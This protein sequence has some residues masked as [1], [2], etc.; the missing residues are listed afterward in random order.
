MMRV[1]T[2]QQVATHLG[3][4]PGTVSAV[5][6]DSPAAKGIPQRTKDRI[7]AGAR[8]LN[9][10][11]NLIARV[12]RKRRTLTIG[13][14]CETIGDP[15]GALVIG[16]IE[17]FLRTHQYVF[18]TMAHHHDSKLVQQYA[19]MLRARGIEGLITVDT[20]LEEPSPVPTVAIAGHYPISGVTNL[21]LDHDL[22]A[23][24]ALNH[25]AELG[26]QTIAFLQGPPSSSDSA[27]RWRCICNSAGKMGIAI[28]P[29][30]TVPLDSDDPSPQTGYRVVK[31]LL[32]RG[33]SF[34]ALFSYND[35]SAIGAIRAIREVGW[36]VPEDISVVGFDD[37][38]DAEFYVP[39]LTTIRQPL[40]KMGEIAA[41]ILVERL[42]GCESHPD[43][44]AVAPELVVRESTAKT[45]PGTVR[46]S[47]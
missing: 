16:G 39:S 18:V 47:A 21:G 35:L 11:P 42:E 33:P 29:Q 43:Q 10:R 13:V 30:L 46:L 7:F 32:S 20:S 31:E 45:R 26:H 3:L 12:L 37:I 8:E 2:L 4:T 14:I 41:Q 5:L 34:T 38:P 27:E 36:R 9:Y 44:I 25:L 17:A 6:N 19:G 15:Y 28:S 40:A 24:L 1:V 22:A 23:D